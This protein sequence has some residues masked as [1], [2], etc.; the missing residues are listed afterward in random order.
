MVLRN[1]ALLKELAQQ[2]HNEFRNQDEEDAGDR[3]YYLDTVK[4][5]Q[6]RGRWRSQMENKPHFLY[7]HNYYEYNKRLYI[8]L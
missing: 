2:I 8:V 6:A 5:G 3:K 4:I 7:E 1:S